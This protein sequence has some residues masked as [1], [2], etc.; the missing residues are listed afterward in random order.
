MCV[1]TV[2]PSA[3]TWASKIEF[4]LS[5]VEREGTGKKRMA[6]QTAI[7]AVTTT[8]KMNLK[9][10]KV[11]QPAI[12]AWH[13]QSIYYSPKDSFHRSTHLTKQFLFV[14]LSSVA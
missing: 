1:G 6:K 9:K 2:I 7:T 14:V 10:V 4:S 3:Y 12:V 5:S 13:I 11:N 8:I